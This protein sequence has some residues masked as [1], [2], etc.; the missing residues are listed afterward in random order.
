[1][2]LRGDWV[3]LDFQLAELYEIETRVL[4]QAVRRNPSRFPPDF[5]FELTPEELSGLRSQIVTSN[6]GGLRYL[7]FA[8]TEQGVAML[9]SVLNSER[10]IQ[11]NIAIMRTFVEL[12]RQ[13]QANRELG[14]R[15]DRLE[16]ETLARLEGQA[17]DIRTIFEV[18][19]RLTAAPPSPPRTPIG[20]QPTP[21]KP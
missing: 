15:L 8:F 11:V 17:D 18:L 1:M 13:G 19:R 5:L 7:P 16:A 20:F 4:K 2:Q 6:R 14:E 21:P 3:L 10:A 12:R 9:S